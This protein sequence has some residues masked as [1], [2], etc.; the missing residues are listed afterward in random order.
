MVSLSLS[1][2]PSSLLHQEDRRAETE[3]ITTDSLFLTLAPLLTPSNIVQRTTGVPGD[4][5]KSVQRPT[6]L[7]F[8]QI[9]IKCSASI[10]PVMA[11]AFCS[12]WI[13]WNAA[14]NVENIQIFF[15][16]SCSELEAV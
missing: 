6:S 5:Q 11:R 12:A 13:I 8:R 14:E 4:P 9:A 10:F 7:V 1:M 3:E 16:F 2:H 15:L